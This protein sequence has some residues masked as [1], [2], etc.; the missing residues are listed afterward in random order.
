[1]METVNI[2][3]L[4]RDALIRLIESTWP[5]DSLSPATAAVGRNLY[6]LARE[7]CDNWRNAPDCVLRHYA[8]LCTQRAAREDDHQARRS[9]TP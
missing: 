7:A 3:N 5:A 1:M 6:Q 9:R 8:T 4:D 2:P